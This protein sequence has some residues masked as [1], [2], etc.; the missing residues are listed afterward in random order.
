[1]N[2]NNPLKQFLK[3]TVVLAIFSFY[4]YAIISHVLII[5]GDFTPDY[6][7][8]QMMLLII[9]LLLALILG[10]IYRGQKKKKDDIFRLLYHNNN[11]AIMIWKID[12]TVIDVNERY[13]ELIGYGKE[14]IGKNWL[15]YTLDEQEDFQLAS[16]IPELLEKKRMQNYVSRA[17][18]KDGYVN[19]IWNDVYLE[20]KKY[21]VSF[22]LDLTKELDH[23][24]ALYQ[25]LTI[26]QLT[27]LEN[28]VLFKED[29]NRWLIQNRKFVV[30]CINMDNFKSLNDVHGHQFGDEMLQKYASYIHLK[31]R[32]YRAYRW[33]GDTMLILHEFEEEEEVKAYIEYLQSFEKMTWRLGEL[34]YQTSLSVGVVKSSMVENEV[35]DLLKKMD[36]ALN[37]A[38]T[39]GKNRTI[40]YSDE[41]LNEVVH[42]HNLEKQLVIAVNEDAF[43][44]Y[45]QPIM[46][47]KIGQISSFEVLLR[48]PDGHAYIG[49]IGELISFAEKTGQISLIDKYVIHKTLLMLQD[50]K[51]KFQEYLVSI[52]VSSQ[53][54]TSEWFL[55]FVCDEMEVMGVD[56][57]NIV[58]EITEYTFLDKMEKSKETM[59][60]LKEIGI[61]VALDDFG[62]KFSSLAYLVELPFM[63]LKIDKMYIDDI[64]EHMNYQLIVEMLIQLAR[65]L[66]MLVVAEGIEMEEQSQLLM[67]MDC[68]Y[69]Q[70]YLHYRPMPIK[71]VLEEL[72]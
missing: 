23:Q 20:S 49:N 27:G 45:L 21:I 11:A 59:F 57:K 52:N 9:S 71:Q 50:H 6:S 64:V 56:P 25:S 41:L 14:L 38:K 46:N 58:F 37:K 28:I 40:I 70:G 2:I 16:F 22:G 31:G 34:E 61:G 67:A 7:A 15:D 60:R 44:L 32:H 24:K 48:W 63:I 33:Q 65:N 18:T 69:G 53:T 17:K 26:D 36:I 3:Y 43:E 47:Y 42:N 62:T 66:D 19:M 30:Y 51:E 72:I 55:E 4:I 68:D 29:V 8:E 12:G 1:M 10:F 35:H 13:E 39:L 5:R 54:F